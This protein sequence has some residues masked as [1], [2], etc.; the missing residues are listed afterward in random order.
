MLKGELGLRRASSSPTG[1]R[2]GSSP[3]TTARRWR[4][5]CWPAST[6]SWSRSRRPTTPTAGTCS[7]PTLDLARRGRRGADEPHRRRGVADP[8]GEV[9]AR[10][11]RAPVHRPAPT[12]TRSAARRTARSPAGR[13]PSR[14]CC[15]GTSGSTLPLSR[16]RGQPVYVAGS[17]ADNIGNQAGGWTLTWQ[18]G[19]T[20]VIPGQTV[21]DAVRATVREA[22]VQF[23]ETGSDPVPAQRGRRRGGRRDAVRRGLR[24]RRRPA[25]GLR[26]GRQ[27]RP[28][29]EED[30]A[31]QRRR[32][33]GDP[34]G[35]LARR[36]RAPCSSSPVG[37]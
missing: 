1:G 21:L 25:V 18:G 6:C 33:A 8:D 14:R 29:A 12:S 37:R 17:N 7:S 16:G 28:A 27:R 15:S 5:R 34:H 30:H 20:N 22:G 36:R 26:P 31:A 32:P 10:A 35:L 13:S 23:S 2:S 4:R 3:A 11:L 9:R 19:S 24:R